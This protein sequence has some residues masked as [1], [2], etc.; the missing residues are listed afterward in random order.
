[1]AVRAV[2]GRT[3]QVDPSAFVAP[4]AEVDGD[5]VLGARSSVWYG[6]VLRGDI[7]PIRVGAETS[8][9]D[10]AV[11][12]TDLGFPCEVGA[13]V[14]VGHRAVLHG[15]TVEDEALIGMGAIVLNGARVGRGALVA[16]GALVPEGAVVPAGAVAMGVPARVV[17][18]VRPEEAE[19]MRQG[20][21]HY[22]EL[23]ARHRAAAE[24]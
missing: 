3:P 8:V 19:R 16:A 18:A 1:M 20:V 6:A 22:V 21:A 10:G 9:Q 2:G 24:A 23:A 4:G 11:L 17:R 15:C 12:H 13:R 5:V 7:A 14:T